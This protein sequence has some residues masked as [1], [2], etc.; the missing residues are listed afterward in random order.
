MKSNEKMD[1]ILS[2]AHLLVA[3]NADHEKNKILL[4]SLTFLYFLSNN[5]TV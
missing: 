5:I 3:E 4:S 1:K 2:Y